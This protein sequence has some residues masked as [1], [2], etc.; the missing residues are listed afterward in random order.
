MG[1]RRPSRA[2]FGLVLL[3]AG[4]S[5]CTDIPRPFK[6][7]DKATPLTVLPADKRG[8]AV[9]PVAGLATLE[10]GDQFAEAM[11]DALQAQDL[12]ASAHGVK[13][14]LNFVLSGR[15]DLDTPGGL[16]GLVD[17]QLTVHWNLIDAQGDPVGAFQQ[18]GAV[19]V[20]E[21]S[22]AEPE[23]L[24]R[25][26]R[27]AAPEIALMVRPNPPP[28]E[29][30]PEPDGPVLTVLPA[31][32]ATGDGNTALPLAMKA[33]MRARRV[34][35]A[36]DTADSDYT[37][38]GAVEV[39]PEK[40]GTRALTVEWQLRRDTGELVGRLSQSNPV[41][42]DA[43]ASAW[44]PLANVIAEAAAPEV[45]RLMAV[46]MENPDAPLLP[47]PLPPPNPLRG[48]PAQG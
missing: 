18:R 29:A 45:V 14:K 46:D 7:G 4:L 47:A 44:G 6:P 15:A 21:F 25:L 5:A 24:E 26:A 23:L 33:R 22:Q 34:S 41:P 28:V 19:A 2:L 35:L 43:I 8:I 30:E 37:L 12:P 48:R 27:L 36:A 32:G 40:T 16:R 10:Q 13:S 38:V 20:A 39:G 1:G 42:T 31:T 3:L 17:S 9:L 11:V